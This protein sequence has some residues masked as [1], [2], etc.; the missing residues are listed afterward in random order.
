M[1]FLYTALIA[2]AHALVF[3]GAYAPTGLFGAGLQT[4]AWLYNFWKAGLP[5]AVIAYSLLKDDHSGHDHAAD[6]HDQQHQDH[7]LRAAYVHVIADAATMFI[8]VR[9][10]R[11]LPIGKASLVGILLPIVAPMVVVAALQ[12]PIKTLLL[13]LLKTL[14]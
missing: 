2:V 11:I 7:N 13:G 4:T 1:G 6:P 9:S 14:I 3:P 8:A 12:I 5:L 10:M